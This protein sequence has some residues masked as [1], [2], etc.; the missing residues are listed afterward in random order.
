MKLNMIATVLG[1]T[2]AMMSVPSLADDS[3]HESAKR[4][5]NYSGMQAVAVVTTSGEPGHGWQY[6]VDGRK[7][8]AV[9]ISPEGA[10]YYSR[11]RGLDLVFEPGAAQRASLTASPSA[12]TA[13]A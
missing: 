6:F 5:R 10:Y 7:H 9:V 8:R 11:G 3:R 13:N 1:V 2:A 12:I 4:D